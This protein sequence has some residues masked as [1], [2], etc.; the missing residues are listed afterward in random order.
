MGSY[1]EEWQEIIEWVHFVA[2]ALLIMYCHYRVTDAARRARE[3]ILL[4]QED[5]KT[6]RQCGS[7]SV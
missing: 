4:G 1:G 7:T 2:I 5:Y 3:E 6:C